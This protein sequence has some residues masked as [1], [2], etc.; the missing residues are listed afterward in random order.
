MQQDTTRRALFGFVG[1]AGAIAALPAIVVA[2]MPPAPSGIYARYLAAKARFFAL[3]EA[4][5]WDDPATFEREE[6]AFLAADLELS[7]T[8]PTTMREFAIWYEVTCDGS[9]WSTRAL[10]LVTSIA[11][12]EGR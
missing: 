2:S 4:V 1:L 3:P 6:Q 12:A 7:A 10:A 5:E 9:E 8:T 11:A